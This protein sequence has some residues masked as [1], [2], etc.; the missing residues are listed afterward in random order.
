M[1][2]LENVDSHLCVRL[3]DRKLIET[4]TIFI[5]QNFIYFWKFRNR[6]ACL[7]YLFM[8]FLLVFEGFVTRK[9]NG[10]I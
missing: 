9:W 5:K 10:K 7:C 2:I 4:N 1:D 3:I 6:N 8:H